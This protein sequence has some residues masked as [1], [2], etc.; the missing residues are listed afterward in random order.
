M[1]L[2]ALAG[3]LASYYWARERIDSRTRLTSSCA[4]AEIGADHSSVSKPDRILTQSACAVALMD[5]L[6]PT[7]GSALSRRDKRTAV[8]VNLDQEAIGG[9]APIHIR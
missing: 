9:T 3:S 1:H 7:K 4:M 6:G 2:D 8:Q 5:W